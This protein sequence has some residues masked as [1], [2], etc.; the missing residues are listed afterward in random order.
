MR[1]KQWSGRI[2][3]P[4]GGLSSPYSPATHPRE[5]TSIRFSTAAVGDGR[6]K[7][8]VAG[9]VPAAAVLSGLGSSW[10]EPPK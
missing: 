5:S 6:L 4:G 8:K 10:A 1:K 2:C 7:A 3:A 9:N